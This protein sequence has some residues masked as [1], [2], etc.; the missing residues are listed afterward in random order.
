MSNVPRKLRD[1]FPF[2]DDPHDTRG[3]LAIAAADLIEQQ[4]E[5]IAE[6][7]QLFGVV[8]E[9]IKKK[10]NRIVEL[11]AA[12]AAVSE[13]MGRYDRQWEIEEPAASRLV[14]DIKAI[15]TPD[16]KGSER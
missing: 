5:R 11:E 13:A 15:L 10:N 9:A 12:V 8:N 4:A 1:A 2:V 3:R 6:L 16:D 14:C 7:E